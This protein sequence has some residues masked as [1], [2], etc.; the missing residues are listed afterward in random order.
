MEWLHVYPFVGQVQ[1]SIDAHQW[2][3]V[4][5]LAVAGN[6]SFFT[7]LFYPSGVKNSVSHLSCKV[8]VLENKRVQ[9]VFVGVAFLL[10]EEIN[11]SEGIK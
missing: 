6:Q 2:H 10:E 4:L 9:I 5:Y 3:N 1:Q 7:Q 8:V 11:I